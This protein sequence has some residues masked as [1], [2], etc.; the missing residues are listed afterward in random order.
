L[1]ISNTTNDALSIF[2]ALSG[3]ELVLKHT[4]SG[5]SSFGRTIQF[6]VSVA[7]E[8]PVNVVE[9]T[10]TGLFFDTNKGIVLKAGNIVTDTTTGTKIGTDANQ[11]LGFFNATPI[12]R[13]SVGA[14]LS[15]G[16]SETN[17]NLATRIN[18]IRTAL[19]NLGLVS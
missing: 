1:R 13:P 16:G 9:I 3:A 17:A 18:D 19:I 14:A 2:Q 10:D 12:I 4:D 11:K 5:L 8:A 7:G 15:T 6:R